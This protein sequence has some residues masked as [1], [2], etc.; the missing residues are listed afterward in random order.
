MLCA[1]ADR[2]GV[3]HL[4]ELLMMKRELFALG[5]ALAFMGLA[6]WLNFTAEP[7]EP[8]SYVNPFN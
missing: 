6:A 2:L 7:V 5:F 8:S 1:C 3:P 4:G